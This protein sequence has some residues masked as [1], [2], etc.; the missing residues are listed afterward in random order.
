MFNSYPKAEGIMTAIRVMSPIFVVCDE[1]GGEKDIQALEYAINSGVKLIATTH[2][3]SIK[4]AIKKKGI[5]KLIS[6]GAFDYI[7][8]LGTKEKVGEVVDI[9]RIGEFND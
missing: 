8:A 1:I 5:T 4:E 7:V 6:E 9:K 3:G 2:A